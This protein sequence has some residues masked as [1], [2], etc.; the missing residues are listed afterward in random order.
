LAQASWAQQPAAY[1]FN[2]VKSIEIAPLDEGKDFDLY[3]DDVELVIA[4]NKRQPVRNPGR[5]PAK[6]DGKAI[7]LDDFE[8]KGAGQ[9]R[10]VGRGRWTPTTWAPWRAIAPRTSEDPTHQDCT[11]I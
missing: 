8:G 6:L 2:D 1:V 10:R 7:V 3:I 11:D 4:P 5:T 9:R